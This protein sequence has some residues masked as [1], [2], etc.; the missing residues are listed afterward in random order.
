MYKVSR[1]QF[2]HFW[3]FLKTLDCYIKSESGMIE[4]LEEFAN[5]PNREIAALVCQN[6]SVL[7][8]YSAPYI[9][10]IYVLSGKISLYLDNKKSIYQ[11]GSLILANK[12]TK[13]DYQELSDETVII[14]FYFKPEYFDDSLLS[15]IIEEPMLYRFF[16]ESIEKDSEQISH[17]CIYQFAILEDT[18][19]YALLLLKQVV[20]MCY[21]NNKVTK[22]AFILLIVE[23]S[24][25]SEEYLI[26]KDSNIS[27]SVLI[28]EILSYIENNIR[29][30]SLEELSTKFYF[31]PN[32][33][34]SLIKHQ[35]GLSYSTWLTTYRIKH[36]KNYLTQTNLS[37]Q[38]IL[39]KIGYSDKT[40][41]FKLFKTQVGMTPGEYRKQ[42]K[43]IF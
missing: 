8:T 40:Y 39:R 18:H 13:I 12:W 15:Q 38:E 34:S 31:H 23:L 33:L 9:R 35:T 27:S 24:H 11:E 6:T 3:D 22:A 7:L 28:K 41:F 21:F 10:I 30:A 5:N 37:I 4:E 43:I 42:N 14:G 1:E 29:T 16:V 25:H 17:F 2:T 19:F 26:L 36:A 20:K 32:Y